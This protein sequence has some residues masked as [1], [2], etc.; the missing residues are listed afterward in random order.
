M[1]RQAFSNY[2]QQ[3][4]L[5]TETQRKQLTQDLVSPG[6][7]GDARWGEVCARPVAC[8][9]CHAQAESLRA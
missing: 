4:S 1:L 2:L 9:H 3:V 7:P 6:D 8:P 5:H